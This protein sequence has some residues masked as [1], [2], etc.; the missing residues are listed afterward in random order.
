MQKPNLTNEKHSLI[1]ATPEVPLVRI[2]KFFEIHLVIKKY[3]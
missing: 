2:S 1:A 3:H